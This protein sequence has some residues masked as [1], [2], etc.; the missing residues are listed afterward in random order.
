MKYFKHIVEGRPFIVRTDHRPLVYA[1][2]QRLDKASPRQQRPL[3]FIFQYTTEIVHV[4][5]EDNLVADALSRV[6][7]LDMPTALDPAIIQA[8]QEQDSQLET[9]RTDT[10]LSL[11][12]LSIGADTV[13]CDVTA[14]VVRPYLPRSLRRKIS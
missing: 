5:G 13:W 1:F 10:S 2:V 12:S 7:A 3:D 14:G 4:K 8:A 11:Q 9:A 6:S